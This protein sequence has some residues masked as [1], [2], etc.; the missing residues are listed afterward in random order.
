MLAIVTKM[1]AHELIVTVGDQHVYADQLDLAYE[2]IH[3]EPLPLP[4]LSINSNV[5]S[6]DDFK[7]ED[8]ELFGYKHHPFIK[9]PVA[10]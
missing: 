10:T 8:F 4:V 3:R 1:D 9:Y 5:E 7:L 6:I 2:Q